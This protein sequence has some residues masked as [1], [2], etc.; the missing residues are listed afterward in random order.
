MDLV[1]KCQLSNTWCA[2]Y[3]VQYIM[4]TVHFILY[5]VNC[6][7]SI[8]HYVFYTALHAAHSVQCTVGWLNGAGQSGPP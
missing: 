5:T 6:T 7:P 1:E 3:S 4:C 2:V 8:I